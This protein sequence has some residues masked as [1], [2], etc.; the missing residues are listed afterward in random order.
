LTEREPDGYAVR[1]SGF[2]GHKFQKV[3]DFAIQDGTDSGKHINIQT[4]NLVVAI[5]ID[6]GSLHLSPVA[7]LILADAGFLNQFVEFDANGTVFLHVLTPLS[8][9]MVASY[10]SLSC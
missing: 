6:L 3:L 2:R 9:K 1:L 8:S 10:E 5:M 4:R 7:E